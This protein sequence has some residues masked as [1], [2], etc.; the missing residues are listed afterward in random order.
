[1]FKSILKQS[2]G[3][4]IYSE[5]G[6]SYSKWWGTEIPAECGWGTLTA[7]MV[8]IDTSENAGVPLEILYSS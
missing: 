1:M 6:V 8:E 5:T 3:D 2:S 7:E 4:I